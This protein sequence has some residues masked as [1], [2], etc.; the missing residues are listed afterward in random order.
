MLGYG[1]TE[2]GVRGVRVILAVLL[3]FTSSLL[4]ADDTTFILGGNAGD[5]PSL[6][7]MAAA[8]LVHSLRP[9]G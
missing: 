1:Q 3:V 5:C 2:F 6:S 8:P 9:D 7:G 4:L